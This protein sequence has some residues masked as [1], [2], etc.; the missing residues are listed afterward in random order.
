MSHLPK[1]K[2][3]I[4][5]T[6]LKPPVKQTVINASQQTTKSQKKQTVVQKPKPQLQAKKPPAPTPHQ[7]IKE[8]QQKLKA[9]EKQPTLEKKT[10]PLPQPIET[11]PSISDENTITDSPSIY[12]GVFLEHL[13]KTLTLPEKGEVEVKIYFFETGEVRDVQ[14]LRSNSAKNER[15]LKEKLKEIKFSQAEKEHSK[16]IPESFILVFRSKN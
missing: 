3:Q 2:I 13:Q 5:T 12:P 16:K 8:I 4:A 11:Q 14:I 1:S 15:F 9:F 7:S 6:Y 10:M